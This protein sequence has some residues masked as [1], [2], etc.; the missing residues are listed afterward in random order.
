M[1][2]Q[3]ILSVW[4]H[5]D[6]EDWTAKQVSYTKSTKVA[7]AQD[8]ERQKNVATK[9]CTSGLASSVFQPCLPSPPT[10]PAL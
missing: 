2:G 10:P 3:L 8:S 9:N 4:S 6:F 7:T 1:E 5:L